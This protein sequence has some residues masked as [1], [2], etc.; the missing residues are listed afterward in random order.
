MGLKRHRETVHA[1][2]VNGHDWNIRF[3]PIRSGVDLLDVGVVG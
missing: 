3:L 2:G 1:L